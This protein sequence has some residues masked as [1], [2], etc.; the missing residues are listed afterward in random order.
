MDYV[1]IAPHPDDEL[2]GC[3][4]IIN[5]EE[6]KIIIIYTEVVE[7]N[8]RDEALKLKEYFPK[9]IQ[10]QLFGQEIPSELL[11]LNNTFLFPDP[12]YETHPA[13]RIWGSYGE[14]LLRYD[15]FDVVFYNTNMIA[16]YIHEVRTP[17]KKEYSLDEVYLSQKSLW[18][19]QKKYVIFEGRVKWMM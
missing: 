13:H 2:I 3:F 17:E 8:R 15:N 6:N 18:Y 16:P 14:K 12:I 9:S 5:K 19:T 1:I 11:H 7:K 10:A 4:E